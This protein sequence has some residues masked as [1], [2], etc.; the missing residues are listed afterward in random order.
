MI[1]T[2]KK[3]KEVIVYGSIAVIVLLGALIITFFSSGYS[4]GP[5]FSVRQPGTITLVIPYADSH[6]FVDD[7]RVGVSSKEDETFTL[8]NTSDGTHTVLVAK[9]G[10]LPWG[11]NIPLKE[12][13]NVVVYP[14][15]APVSA[16][17]LTMTESD[18]RYIELRDKILNSPLP[19]VQ[20]P[21]LS[22][23]QKIAL[24]IEGTNLIA[25]WRGGGTQPR[26][27]CEPACTDKIIVFAANS[28]IKNVDFY[29]N[30][31]DVAMV[32]IKEGVYAIELDTIGVQNFQPLYMGT[33]PRFYKESPKSFFVLDGKSLK[34][35][36]F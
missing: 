20:T 14:F 16:S 27:F 5:G 21:K 23:D 15:L 3:S 36:A 34:E 17:V 35:V 2:L 31:S 8:P 11:K 32:S 18:A 6:I 9:N 33:E 30:R 1:Q 4:F 28:E 10:F 12:K 24:W 29:M 26:Y 13:Q 25:Q 19:S 22:P 7:V